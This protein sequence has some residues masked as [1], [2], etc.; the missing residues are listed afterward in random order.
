LDSLERASPVHMSPVGPDCVTAFS[1]LRLMKEA[2]NSF[3]NILSFSS[4]PWRIRPSGLFPF[5]IN[6]KLRILQTVGRTPWLGDRLVTRPL[7]T[8]S[9]NTQTNIPVSKWFLA[10]DSSVPSGEGVSCHRPHGHCD[11]PENVTLCTL[12]QII[13]MFFGNISMTEIHGLTQKV[14]KIV[15]YGICSAVNFAA[16]GFIFFTWRSRTIHWEQD[17]AYA[18]TNIAVEY[19]ALL[20][21]REIPSSHLVP[22]TGYVGWRFSW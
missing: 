20:H 6:L 5:R 4:I 15:Q 1:S 11:P 14:F 16:V 21:I 13:V 17:R 3:R 12:S 22:E 9:I 2:D 10:H 18:L 19:V 7:P 8:H